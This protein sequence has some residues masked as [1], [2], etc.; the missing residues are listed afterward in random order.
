[1]QDISQNAK[2]IS[3]TYKNA[4]FIKTDSLMRLQKKNLKFIKKVYARALKAKDSDKNFFLPVH[5]EWICDNYYIIE[6]EVKNIC[7]NLSYFPKLPASKS[8]HKTLK[9][10][11]VRIYAMLLE[12]THNLNGEITPEILEKYIDSVQG[13]NYFSINELSLVRVM[14]AAAICTEIYNICL[15]LW[16]YL[17]AVDIKAALPD[18]YAYSLGFCI[19]NLRFCSIYRFENLFEKCSKTDEIFNGDPAGV[20]KNLD[21]QTKNY[22]RKRLFETAR[23][24]GTDETEAAR[25]IYAKALEARNALYNNEL[26]EAEHIKLEKKSHVGYYLLRKSKPKNLYFSGVFFL[27][28]VFSILTCKYAGLTGLILVVPLWELAKQ[29]CEFIF[30]RISETTPLPKLELAD[31]PDDKK[32]LVCITSLLFGEGKDNGL[33]DRLE[34]FYKCN[35]SKNLNFAILGDFKDSK[36]EKN[37][38]D[39]KI[40]EYAT[41]RIEELNAKYN[42]A[43]SLFIRGRVYSKSEKRYMGWERKRGA[44]IELVRFIKDK[45]TTVGN[46]TGDIN[47]IRDVK[48]V[49]T[50]DADTN[51]SIDSAKEMLAAMLHPSAKPVFDEHKKIITD[52]YAIMQPRMGA[53]LNAS[54]KTP[55]TRMLCGCGG[56]D[57][58]QS[59]AFD[60][61]QQIYGE[62]NFCGKGI[63]DVDMFYK[64]LDG[65]YPEESVLSHDLL[66][67]TRLRCALISDLELTDGIPAN[68]VA[69]FD[70]L[71]RWI[72]GDVQALAFAGV[73]VRNANGE[74]TRNP[75]SALSKY[76]IFDNVRRASLP[77]FS[78]AAI[79][80]ALLPV[81]FYTNPFISRRSL[82]IFILSVSYIIFPMISGIFAIF[83][84][85][86]FQNI[87]KRFS[88]K[89]MTSIW[90]SVCGVLFDL[91]SLAYR[92]FLSLDAIMRSLFRLITRRRLLSWVT[93]SEGEL[94]L[95]GFARYLRKMFLPMI[96]GLLFILFAPLGAYKILGLM[97][98]AFPAAAYAMGKED[99]RREGVLTSKQDERLR[100]Y[101]FDMWKFYAAT[102]G[103]HDNFLPPDNIQLFPVESTAHRTSPTNIG[104]YMLSVLAARDFELTDTPVMCAKL[105]STLATIEKM[106]KWHGHLYN[107]YDTKNLKVIGSRFISTVDSGNFAACLTALKEGLREYQNTDAL[108][109]RIEKILADTQF[110][111]LYNNTRDLFYIGYDE[112]A[113]SFGENCYDLYMSEA[114]ITSYYTIARREVPKKHWQKLGRML[115]KSGGYMGLASWTGT[116][117]EYFMPNLLLPLGRNSLTYEAHKFALREQIKRRGKYNGVEVWGISESGFYAFDFDMNYQYQ[118]FGV[119]KLGL[120]RGLNKDLVISPYSSFLALSIAPGYALSNLA[121]LEKIGMY[122]KYGFYEAAD[123]TSSRVGAGMSIVRSYMAHHIGMSIIAAANACCDNIFQKRFMRDIMQ[124]SA[125]ELLQEKIPVD[126]I[127]FEDINAREIPEK[128]NRSYGFIEKN[129][130]RINLENPVC[131]I[132]SNSK[133]RIT[134]SSSGDIL[135]T[136]GALDI[137]YADFDRYNNL[138]QFAVIFKYKDEVFSQSKALLNKDGAEYGY[139]FTESQAQY[140]VKKII[141]DQRVSAHAVYAL[142]PD[143]SCFIISAEINADRDKKD[144]EIMLYF[145]P[146]LARIE[147]FKAHPAFASLSIEAEYDEKNKILFYKRRPRLESENE[148]WLAI[149]A[150]DTSK[151][152]KYENTQLA[153]ESRR[154]DILPHCYDESDIQGLFNAKFKNTSGA[155]INP[156]SAVKVKRGKINFYISVAN[157]REEAISIIRAAKM[158]NQELE[159]KKIAE[160]SRNRFLISGL[161]SKNLLDII[162]SCIYCKTLNNKPESIAGFSGSVKSLWKEGISGDLP[163]I[164]LIIK[165]EEKADIAEEYLHVHKYLNL[166]GQKLDLVIIYSEA[167]KYNRPCKNKISNLIKKNDCQHYLKQK[168]GIFLLDQSELEA[169][170][171]NIL[172]ALASYKY[173]TGAIKAVPPRDTLEK[174]PKIITAIG[175]VVPQEY[176]NFEFEKPVYEVHGGYFSENN[177]DYSFYIDCAGKKAPWS[178]ILANKQFGTLITHKSLGFTWFSNARERRVTAWENDPVSG[179]KSERLILNIIDTGKKF[180]LCALASHLKI[181]PNFAEYYGKINGLEYK[182]SVTVDEKLFI[183]LVDFTYCQNNTA[184][185]ENIEICYIAKPVMGV[186][187]SKLNII[188]IDE[189]KSDTLTFKNVCSADFNG[190]TGY[191][192]AIGGKTKSRDYLCFLTDGR[193]NANEHDCVAV[194]KVLDADDTRAIFALGCYKTERNFNYLHEKLS[195]YNFVNNTAARSREFIYK[196]MPALK[197]DTGDKALDAMF[198]T[199]APYQNIAARIFGR[200]GFYQS[201][202]AYGFRDQIQ[203]SAAIIY[204]APELVRQHIFRAATHQFIEGD[205]QHWW[206]NIKAQ[207]SGAAH[208]G[209]RTRCSDDYLWLPY[210]TSFYIDKTG[211]DKILDVRVAYIEDEPLAPDE[212]ERYGEPRKSN[213]KESIYE[214]CK[215]SIDYGMKFGAHDLPLI[216]TCDWNDGM[217]LVGAGGKGESVW[218]A[219]FMI[220]VLRDF[221]KVCEIKQDFE[222]IERYKQ[223]CDKLKQAIEAH[224]FEGD[225]YIR[226]FYD[227]G[228]KLGS[229]E[230]DECQIDILPQSFAAMLNGDERAKIAMDSAYNRLFDKKYRIL[231]LFAPPFINGPQDPGYIKGY[232]A[233]IR[234]NGGQYTHGAIWGA[235]GFFALGDSERGREMIRALNPA[236]RCADKD[237][238]QIYKIEPYVFAGDVYAN[239]AHEGR[240]GWS[241][242]TGSAAWFYRAVYDNM[243]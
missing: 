40:I 60:L 144:S 223:T 97:W 100:A 155:C 218:L 166:S 195:D 238:A 32:T 12:L 66:E 106:E 37:E 119:Q 83:M 185:L 122:G 124:K 131:R 138:K 11:E 47:F 103:K 7:K 136:D 226:G 1:M 241:W 120:K 114:K 139:E 111:A 154:D 9:K 77:V 78:L 5:F 43:F 45:R 236:A 140:S 109:L 180:D 231:K 168:G 34:I 239:S 208:R 132:I 156:V 29:I 52:G 84:V 179:M 35:P 172:K 193:M 128:I 27:T 237:L 212:K 59:A 225:R 18:S 31:I 235:L 62:G 90:Q 58:Y 221:I 110:Q 69:Y 215:R 46:F 93:A 233:G 6:R 115:I 68:P 191:L 213:I 75:I 127:I 224:C 177:L 220:L 82:L 150:V 164:L 24:S 113:G 112:D 10:P 118:A 203:D 187:P 99:A 200:T 16:D 23:D 41:H 71:H 20:Y 108:I 161:K 65:A 184:N 117:F 142:S 174:I 206:H 25:R 158:K 176:D 126:A 198:N 85:S 188:D 39:A 94:R 125:A 3:L 169:E 146:I 53:E 148:K 202:G 234:E 167:E 129:T 182:I 214:H 63:F 204:H 105:E 98:L 79:I 121:R 243:R 30:A 15:E 76:K 49:I 19:R 227:N 73:R 160:M 147:D 72:R 130:G 92:A 42:N 48:Y 80:F 219:F 55:F 205:V 26:S 135:L 67:G 229:K 197:L 211:D 228:D 2:N 207:D 101:I 28:A 157:K 190:Y 183:K 33:Y 173:E 175:A 107:W 70:R 159:N 64:V 95:T 50:L 163:I 151:S 134:A 152:N 222:A 165:D 194:S 38:A 102:V 89:V 209:V 162:L 87:S 36:D 8:N 210:I 22:Y 196:Y 145:E 61:Y 4:G 240:G 170:Q 13:G 153:F 199:F 192:R 56:V 217:S 86:S 44:L 104:L 186:A 123:F 143:S 57:I 116:A 21:K 230:R 149:C 141:D 189:P 133:S 216:G 232:V 181:S 17:N 91:A 171:V 14:L 178:H 96:I 51:L 88:S 74:R 54:A 242:Y 201:S 137:N 81:Y